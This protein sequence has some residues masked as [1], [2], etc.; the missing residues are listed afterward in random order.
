MTGLTYNGFR[1]PNKGLK[2]RNALVK[3]PTSMLPG[4]KYD[5]YNQFTPA[6]GN[7][8]GQTKQTSP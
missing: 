8:H 4:E 6:R 1:A 5:L 3:M 7:Y 2:L